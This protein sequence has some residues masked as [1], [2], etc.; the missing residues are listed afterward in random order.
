M[1]IK[2]ILFKYFVI[3]LIT[4]ITTHLSSLINFPFHPNYKFPLIHFLISLISSLI[5]IHII[6]G[7]YSLFEWRIFK[8]KIGIEQIVLFVLA[9]LFAIGIY[10][11]FYF[12]TTITII[13]YE[14]ELYSF[15]FSLFASLVLA[16]LFIILFYGQKFI[17]MLTIKN[18]RKHL[19]VR[20]A[21]Q[22][23]L[24]P[25]NEILCFYSHLKTVF[26]VDVHGKRILTNF[27]LNELEGLLSKEVFFRVNR[28]YLVSG[29]A[30][31]KVSPS[32]ND[33]LDVTLKNELKLNSPISVS[34]YKSA[35]FKNWLMNYN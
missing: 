26:L 28:Q 18:T 33:K 15:V 29:Y 6:D 20:S 9:C 17:Q 13:G 8:N 7:I 35:Q 14:Y 3:V 22:I 30:V 21:K 23:H 34:R 31:S 19:K 24:I 1:T 5:V 10:F 25:I 12:F 4:L 32:E 27:T 11:P 16:S 2:R